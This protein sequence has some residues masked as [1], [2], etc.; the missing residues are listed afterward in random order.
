MLSTIS[1][2][3]GELLEKKYSKPSGPAL[4]EIVRE[5]RR[6]NRK[7]IERNSLITE[8]DDKISRLQ[9]EILHAHHSRLA[10]R[11]GVS[12]NVRENLLDQEVHLIHA[13]VWQIRL[14]RTL[15]HKARDRAER[16]D[17]C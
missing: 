17:G 10:F 2:G 14:A 1:Q 11:I 15:P 4:I 9:H 13:R 12:C 16:L 3:I 8:V 7:R 5:V 6:T